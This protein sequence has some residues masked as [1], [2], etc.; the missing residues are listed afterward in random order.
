MHLQSSYQE[1]LS[2]R[3]SI[4]FLK[5][6]FSRGRIDS[7]C[8]YGTTLGPVDSHQRCALLRYATAN[9]PLRGFVSPLSHKKSRA[10]A[11]LYS[12]QVATN[13]YRHTNRGNGKDFVEPDSASV[14]DVGAEDQ[15]ATKARY[16][17]SGDCGKTGD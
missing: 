8:D 16:E 4:P 11:R 2:F 10:N 13:S 9:T 12:D 1:I 3:L 14:S 15:R 7:N 6:R 17:I 5:E